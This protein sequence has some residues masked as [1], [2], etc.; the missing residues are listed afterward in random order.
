MASIMENPSAAQASSQDSF[1]CPVR[2]AANRRRV[3]SPASIANRIRAPREDKFT[4][5][6]MSQ[7]VL[8]MFCA[9]VLRP[10]R[11]SFFS[12]WDQLVQKLT[13]TLL[14]TAGPLDA[15]VCEFP[16]SLIKAYAFYIQTVACLVADSFE[17]TSKLLQHDEFVFTEKCS[18]A[19]WVAQTYRTR[20]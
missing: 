2:R 17:D 12:F 7:R 10:V 19:Y 14:N 18:G 13:Q 3:E 11:P 4:L 1:M 5:A 15:D 20:R 8:V 9:A 6:V 16:E